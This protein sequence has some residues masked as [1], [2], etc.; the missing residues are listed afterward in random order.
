MK[1]GAV[2]C[3]SD[4][5]KSI[6]QVSILLETERP[7]QSGELFRIALWMRKFIGTHPT[8]NTTWGQGVAETH[9]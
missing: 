1:G 8:Q 3:I 2:G 6:Y 7:V 5:V 9:R 4:V